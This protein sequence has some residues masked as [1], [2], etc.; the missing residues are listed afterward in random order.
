[1]G[2]VNLITRAANSFWWDLFGSLDKTKQKIKQFTQGNTCLV[3][4]FELLFQEEF[5][6]SLKVDGFTLA[7]LILLAHLKARLQTTT[8][9][10]SSFLSNCSKCE[11]RR[12]TNWRIVESVEHICPK[13]GGQIAAWPNQA[14]NTRWRNRNVCL[15]KNKPCD[16]KTSYGPLIAINLQSLEEL[17]QVSLAQ[18]LETESFNVAVINLQNNHSYLETF[19]FVQLSKLFLLQKI[20]L[21]KHSSS[22]TWPDRHLANGNYTEPVHNTSQI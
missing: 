11:K 6:M 8:S 5:V 16:Y 12:N 2:R 7:G 10:A 9:T 13:S 1:M 22:F 21:W 15:P 17:L 3:I 20:S 18:G 14:C 4:L 19:I